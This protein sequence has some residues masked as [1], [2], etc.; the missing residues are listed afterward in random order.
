MTL[1]V[2]VRL[3]YVVTEHR[4]MKYQ[5]LSDNRL[6]PESASS[7]ISHVTPANRY[8]SH[9]RAAVQCKGAHDA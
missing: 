5:D 6:G 7:S 1:T 3:V 8:D 9:R 4:L 2:L